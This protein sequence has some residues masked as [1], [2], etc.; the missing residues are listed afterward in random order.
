MVH[1]R[2]AGGRQ[3]AGVSTHDRG[4]A[5]RQALLRRAVITSRQLPQVFEV[6]HKHAGQ[7]GAVVVDGRL[8]ALGER[9]G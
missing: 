8:Q 7:L 1:G 2:D 4:R 6:P 5:G 3:L 9:R